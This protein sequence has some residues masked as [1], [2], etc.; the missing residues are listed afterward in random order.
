VTTEEAREILLPYR[1]G[2]GDAEDPQIAEA[3][4]LA[5]QDPELARWLEAHCARQ[6]VIS[7][8]FRR[9]NPPEGLI[10]QII[11]EHRATQKRSFLER[12]R[13]LTALVSAMALLIC[14]FIATDPT[15]WWRYFQSTDKGLAAYQTQMAGV[16]LS[17]YGMGLATNDTTRILAYLKQNNAPSDF[18]LN[19]TLKQTPM[20]G[21]AVEDWQGSPVTMLCFHSNPAGGNA[22]TSDLWLFVANRNLISDAPSGAHPQVHRVGTLLIATWVDGDRLYM[23]AHQG[24]LEDLKKFL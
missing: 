24:E 21:C 8:K 2:T 11:S 9:L 20:T 5:R 3:L 10:Q 7:E 13:T 22:H 19:A 17:P 14:L 12:N 4:T 23:L 18:M 15:E 16:A 6:Y 1:H